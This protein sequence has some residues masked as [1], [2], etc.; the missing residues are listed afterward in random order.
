MDVFHSTEHY[1][2]GHCNALMQYNNTT[3]YDIRIYSKTAKLKKKS[4]ALCDSTLYLW[5]EHLI[6]KLKFNLYVQEI[7]NDCRLMWSIYI[8]AYSESKLYKLCKQ[9]QNFSWG[10]ASDFDSSSS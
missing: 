4:V 5:F 2:N 3:L 6:T 8:Y 10:N 7:G 1:S 9:S